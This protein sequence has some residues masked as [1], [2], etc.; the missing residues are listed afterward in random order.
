[1]N[2]SKGNF[3][4]FKKKENQSF[5]SSVPYNKRSI[6]KDADKNDQLIISEYNSSYKQLTPESKIPFETTVKKF[7]S[8]ESDKPNAKIRE[9]SLIQHNN[10]DISIIFSLTMTNDGEIYHIN[11]DVAKKM[12]F[13][14]FTLPEI[15][16]IKG[17]DFRFYARLSVWGSEKINRLIKM[18]CNFC[19]IE[20]I[21]LIKTIMDTYNIISNEYDDNGMNALLSTLATE[22]E[23]GLDDESLVGH[24]EDNEGYKKSLDSILKYREKS[25][26]EFIEGINKTKC[27]KN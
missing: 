13:I 19:I 2:D 1:M 24:A 27:I 8:Y 21:E 9:F 16:T 14:G 12:L 26:L 15:K 3:V 7:F 18:L 11:H 4:E 17:K 10:N 22:H 20:D 23:E 25:K 5:S 6:F